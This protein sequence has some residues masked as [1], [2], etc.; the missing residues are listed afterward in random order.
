MR[1]TVIAAEHP[2][3]GSIRPY[4]DR[5]ARF[6]TVVSRTRPKAMRQRDAMPI[7]T[8]TLRRLWWLWQA[9]AAEAFLRIFVANRYGVATKW[10]FCGCKEK[11]LV[12]TIHLTLYEFGAAGRN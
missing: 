12:D 4:L 1:N 8:A 10:G 2:V 6:H 7:C 3:H 5:G 11:G 9:R